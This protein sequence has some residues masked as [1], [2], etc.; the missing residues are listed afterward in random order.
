MLIIADGRGLQWIGKLRHLV[1]ITLQSLNVQKFKLF[2]VF[3]I[4]S[5]AE[6]FKFPR[7]YFFSHSQNI[8]L[9]R[10]SAANFP[11]WQFTLP[12]NHL[13][14]C[15]LP[16]ESS[17]NCQLPWESSHNSLWLH[18]HVTLVVRSSYDC[19]YHNR[20]LTWEISWR[21]FCHHVFIRIIQNCSIDP[22]PSG[23]CQESLSSRKDFHCNWCWMTSS[24]NTHC[25]HVN[26]NM[27]D[28]T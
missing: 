18:N 10:C 14:L 2:P 11:N 20:I 5:S 21:L 8:S 26:E 22:L 1:C 7:L 3:Y 12:G 13:P 17:H 19:P 16:W 23:I 4:R 24:I 27:K 6:V 28:P 9:L 25:C 15:Q